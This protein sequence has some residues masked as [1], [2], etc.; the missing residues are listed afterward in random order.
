MLSRGLQDKQL[1]ARRAGTVA[2]SSYD[3][4]V[5]GAGIAGLVTANRAAQL[6]K[7]VVVL[8][9]STEDKYICNSRYAY[10][11]IH[12]NYS[13]LNQDEDV[14]VGRI[15]AATEGTARK[16][17]A[18]AVA[19]DGRRLVRVT[20]R[21][22]NRGHKPESEDLIQ[23]YLIDRE[24]RLWGESPGLSGVR[25]TTRVPAGQS[26]LSEPVFAVSEDATGLKLVFTRGHRQPGVLV[27]GDSDSLLHQRTV[28]P[29]DQR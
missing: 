13:D 26:V 22:A 1:S 7:R 2:E 24:G 14:L 3:V 16:D 10:G 5:I 23:A 21:I 29:L 15:E 12:I 17:L 9:K 18:R 28:V 6:G 27:I 11:T 4:I 8:E 19:K 20:V 25:L